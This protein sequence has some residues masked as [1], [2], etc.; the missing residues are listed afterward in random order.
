MASNF[1]LVT[2]GPF[3][4]LLQRLGLGLRGL[5]NTKRRAGAIVV[6][7]WVPLVILSLVQGLAFGTLPRRRIGRSTLLCPN[8]SINYV[9]ERQNLEHRSSGV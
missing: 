8:I 1:S 4:N 3:Y 5:P 9:V 7:T 6:I 2:G